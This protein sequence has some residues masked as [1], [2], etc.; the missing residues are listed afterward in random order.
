M[1][2]K[3]EEQEYKLDWLKWGLVL[4]V[5]AAGVYGNAHF[6]D[7]PL[8]Y[9]VIGLLVLSVVAGFVAIQTEKGASAWRLIKESRAEIRRVVWPTRQE[10]T[11]TTLI[12]VAVVLVMAVILWGLDSALSWLVSLIIG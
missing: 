9:R 4:A 3:I 10:T 8:L 6:G 7:Q 11:Q 12:V 5:V 2:A 1:S